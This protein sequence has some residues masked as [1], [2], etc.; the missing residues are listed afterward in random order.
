MRRPILIPIVTVEDGEGSG[1]DSDPYY[2]RVSTLMF[3]VSRSCNMS[4]THCSASAP[5]KD[6]HRIMPIETARAY[7]DNVLSVGAPRSVRIVFTGGEPTLAPV[8]WFRELFSHIDDLSKVY[9][10]TV[11]NINVKTNLL[12]VSDDL[13]DLLVERDAEVCVSL[14]GPPEINDI[15]RESAE[16][17]AR[18]VERVAARGLR[19]RN[20]CV[21][22]EHNYD[23]IPEVIEYLTILGFRDSKFNPF[24]AVGRGKRSDG[25]IGDE[26][27]LVAKKAVLAAMT[28][29]VPPRIVDPLLLNQIERFVRRAPGI[30]QKPHSSCYSKYCAFGYRFGAVGPEGG[31]YGCKRAMSVPQFQLGNVDGLEEDWEQRIDDMQARGPR[32]AECDT[33][34]AAAVCTFGCAAFEKTDTGHGELDCR[35]TKSLYAHFLEQEEHLLSWYARYTGDPDIA[36]KLALSRF[37]YTMRANMPHGVRIEDEQIPVSVGERRYLA[38]PTF[39]SFRPIRG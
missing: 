4:C 19:Y 23:R 28:S 2:S 15:L 10:H 37:S 27:F 16:Q 11:E 14:D 18:N 12:D 36:E 7:A 26:E 30:V 35:W 38:S 39:D 24:Y 31:V 22:S 34:P 6:N 9:G 5:F 25:S 1:C 29:D 33:C 20:I 8:A 32:W 3:S 17:V 13:L 21:V